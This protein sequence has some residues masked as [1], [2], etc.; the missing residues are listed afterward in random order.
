MLSQTRSLEIP[1]TTQEARDSCPKPKIYRYLSQI[2]SLEVY[3]GECCGI[4]VQACVV[5][6]TVAA[7]CFQRVGILLKSER[8]DD[9]VAIQDT[10]G[11]SIANIGIRIFSNVMYTDVISQG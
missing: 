11:G 2:Q 10:P 1:V 8:K 4:P 5:D 6:S 9:Y 3:R 7:D